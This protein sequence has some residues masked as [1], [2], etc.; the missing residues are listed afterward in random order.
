MLLRQLNSS[1]S[2]NLST[3]FQIYKC[4][5]KVLPTTTTKCF[6]DQFDFDW[7]LELKTF[8]RKLRFF[9]PNVQIS[10]TAANHKLKPIIDCLKCVLAESCHK[11][12]NI[13]RTKESFQKMCQS[14]VSWQKLNYYRK[15]R[16]KILKSRV[17]NVVVRWFKKG[18][19]LCI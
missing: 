11:A 16:R 2:G 14:N 4:S 9:P 1:T 3:T 7:I 10:V 13:A 18:L 19:I 12:F 6:H 8:S 5:F 15:L 17:Y